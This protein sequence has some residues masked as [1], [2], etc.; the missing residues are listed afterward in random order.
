MKAFHAVLRVG[1]LRGAR[2]GAQDEPLQQFSVRKS[3]SDCIA[4]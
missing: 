3:T 1:F 2:A 4:S